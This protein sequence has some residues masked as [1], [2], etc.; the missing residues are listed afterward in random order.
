MEWME[1]MDEIIDQRIYIFLSCS[2]GFLQ[3]RQFSFSSESTA[4]ASNLKCVFLWVLWVGGADTLNKDCFHHSAWHFQ[5]LTVSELDAKQWRLEGDKYNEDTDFHVFGNQDMR[6]QVNPAM[7]QYLLWIGPYI[8]ETQKEHTFAVLRMTMYGTYRQL[9][10]DSEDSQHPFHCLWPHK[11]SSKFMFAGMIWACSQFN[12][13]MIVCP[14]GKK[15][16]C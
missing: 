6:Q 8:V 2:H 15:S 11:E 5:P 10:S 14:G 9:I 13:W 7:T 12:S 1:W 3:W 16:K 4:V